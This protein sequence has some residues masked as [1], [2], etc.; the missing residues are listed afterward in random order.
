MLP[1]DMN[2]VKRS[3]PLKIIYFYCGC[4]TADV[5]KQKRG[6]IKILL[7]DMLLMTCNYLTQFNRKDF[8]KEI[9]TEL[10]CFLY[11]LLL[12]RSGKGY[13]D[14]YRDISLFSLLTK[15]PKNRTVTV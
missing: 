1:T 14:F 9:N 15:I 3:P 13:P 2:N 10:Y 6:K 8:I 11:F 4:A 7:S 5:S 12:L